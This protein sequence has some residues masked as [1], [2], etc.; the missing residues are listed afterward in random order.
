MTMTTANN[1]EIAAVDPE[2]EALADA[3]VHVGHARSKRHPAMAPYVWGVRSG[4]DII[5]LTKTKEKLTPALGALTDAARQGKLILFV[6]TRPAVSELLR[7]AAVE[8]G[9]PVVTRRWIGGTLTN[10]RVIRQ[11][12]DALEALMDEES[13]GASG[14]SKHEQGLRENELRRLRECFDGLQELKRLPDLIVIM[15]IAHGALA[16]REARRLGIPVVAITDTNTNPGLVSYPIPAS[17]DARPAIAYMLERMRSAIAEGR[18]MAAAEAEAPS[19]A[20]GA[21]PATDARQ[22]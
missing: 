17:D 16:L 6:G 1:P 19:P 18:R 2:I 14:L 22:D 3:G 20:V 12:I 11:S 15:D 4:V 13:A 21:A 9:Y 10:F 7:A 5:D 8:L